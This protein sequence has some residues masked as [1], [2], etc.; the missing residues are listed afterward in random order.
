MPKVTINGQEFEVAAG[1][2]VLQAALDNSI[3]IP[4]F[5]F[6]PHLPISGCCRMCLVEI[7]G[8]PKQQIACATTVTEGMKVQTETPAV[9]Q[10][11]QAVMEFTLKNHPIDCPIC[12][13]AGE[14]ILQDF[15]M[16]FDGRPSRLS[17]EDGKVRKGKAL[18]LGPT[19]VLDQE[20]CILCDRCVRFMREVA[21][22]EC[23]TFA[24]RH[25]RAVI[26]TFPGQEINNP[27]SLCITDI[28]PVGAWTGRDFRFKKRVWFLK[29]MPSICPSCARGCNITL[30]HADGV[31]YRI[32]PRRND[33]LNL[34]WVCDPGRLAYHA[35]EDRR[36]TQPLIKKGGAMVPA[37]WEEALAAAAKVLKPAAGKMRGIL[38][39]SATCEEGEMF[40]RFCQKALSAP[41]PALLT[42]QPGY[43]DAILIR[44]DKNANR[45]GLEDLGIRGNLEEAVAQ[46]E[47]LLVQEAIPI[48]DLDL[49]GKAAVVLSPAHSRTVDQALVALPCA[50]YSEISGTFV[51]FQGIKQN[52]QPALPAK[53]QARPASVILSQL[54]RQMG[55]KLD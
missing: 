2:S 27:Y 34:S 52:F 22:D 55:K 50:A 20:R 43:E 29:R 4:H 6:H 21:Q 5:C 17:P 35:L 54:A 36:L 12:D 45:K 38:S 9:I 16:R 33:E 31:V 48:H 30:D 49:K 44:A 51:N 23:I 10:S 14:C 40:L 7:E 53:G 26:T 8:M 47:G 13:K 15:Y 46:A 28:C 42:G 19:L 39:A 37:T 3:F 24:Q 11:R 25:D 1:K 18:I 32:M 41:A